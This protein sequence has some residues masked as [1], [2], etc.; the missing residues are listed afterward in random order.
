MPSKVVIHPLVLLSTVD[1]YNRVAKDAKGRRV[2]GVLL[3]EVFKGK[4]DVTNSFAVPFEEDKR[5][6]KVWFIDHNYLEEMA[7]MFRRVNAHEKI[8][9]FYSTGPAIRPVDLQIAA[10]FQKYVKDPVFAI[11]DIRAEREEEGLPVKAYSIVEEVSPEGK[12]TTR[13]FQHMSSEVGAFEAEEVGVEHLLRDINDPSVSSLAGMIRHKITGLNGLKMHLFEMGKYLD[14]VLSGKIPVNNK[15]VYNIQTILNLLPNLNMDAMVRSFFVKTNDMHL[16]LYVSSIVRSIIVL[17]KLLN[18][19][20]KYRD[21]D[22]FSGDGDASKEEEKK[23][24]EE[25]KDAKEKEGKRG[26]TDKTKK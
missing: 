17:H 22:L 18:N 20:L 9:G 16:V 6:K 21:T 19:K 10:M 3:G 12:Q 2:V 15:I 8:V 5:N 26:D 1:H 14:K 4:V 11:I 13:T 24:T 7:E 23:A 25:E